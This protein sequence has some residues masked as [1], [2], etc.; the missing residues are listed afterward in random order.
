MKQYH[1]IFTKDG[2]IL[3]TKFKWNVEK[4]AAPGGVLQFDP[5]QWRQWE[6]KSTQGGSGV[7]E[8]PFRD[9]FQS[10]DNNTYYELIHLKGVV[11]FKIR[12]KKEIV[13]SYKLYHLVEHIK[14]GVVIV[15]KASLWL[16]LAVWLTILMW[17]VWL[18]WGEN[19]WGTKN[20][21]NN[22]KWFVYT[23]KN[24]IGCFKGML[25]MFLHNK[26]YI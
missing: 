11:V 4:Y 23:V 24:K 6:D 22:T 2:N 20:V 14:S 10:D 12:W 7:C 9:M 5:C 13:I 8:Y 16:V 26:N 18:L 19:H 3:K 21:K 15:I 17:T 25:C 1:I